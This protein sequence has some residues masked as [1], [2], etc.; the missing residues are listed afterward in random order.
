MI[1][2]VN[3]KALQLKNNY[4]KNK[5]IYLENVETVNMNGMYMI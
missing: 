1:Q 5:T 3:I 2:L 4:L